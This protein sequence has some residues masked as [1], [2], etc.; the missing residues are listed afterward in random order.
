[1]VL[2]A[3]F[4]LM[5]SGELAWPYKVALQNE[6]KISPRHSVRVTDTTYEFLLPGH[7][8][9]RFFQG[10]RIIVQKLDGVEDPWALR[11]CRPR[12]AQFSI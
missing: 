5:R 8:G 6:R 10:S 9:D 11:D 12:S 2:T 3:F 4:A 1:M 7:K